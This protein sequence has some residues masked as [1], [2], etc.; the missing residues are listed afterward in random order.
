MKKAAHDNTDRIIPVFNERF[1]H[2]S[3]KDKNYKSMYG[4][5]SPD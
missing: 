5:E 2:E 1:K 3:L 4:T